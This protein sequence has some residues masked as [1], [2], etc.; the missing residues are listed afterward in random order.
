MLR[1]FVAEDEKGT[2]NS[3]INIIEN[4][5]PDTI[6]SDYA[7]TVEDAVL[8]LSGNKVDLVLLDINFP[9]GTGFD[10][11]KQLKSYDFHI[12][13]ITAHE[14][15]ALQAIK[16]S[17]ADY[18]LKPLNPK[19][20]IASIQKL[21]EKNKEE[22]QNSLMIEALLTNL[23]IP[24]KSFEKIVLKTAERI[25]VIEIKDIIRC[26]SD[27]SYTSFFLTENRKI[28]V[29]KALKEYDEMLSDAEF[30]RTHKSHLVNINFIESYEKSGGGYIVLKD[31]SNI[32]VSVR[33]KDFVL[34]TINKL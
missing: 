31:K 4:Y 29:S 32:P 26:E 24:K 28:F 15:Y 20:L 13:F 5:C 25:Q 17:A 9:D 7:Q 6:L 14:K 27:G 33:K 1:V 3:I 16:F 30:I 12:I 23:D 2:L 22:S 18:L 34:E 8:F 11:L 21:Q 10:I 19:E